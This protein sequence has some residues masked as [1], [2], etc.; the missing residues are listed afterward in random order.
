MA[1]AT[2]GGKTVAPSLS[3][4]PRSYVFS[5]DAANDLLAAFDVAD[6]PESRAFLADLLASGTVPPEEVEL[7]AQGSS[8]AARRTARRQQRARPT[9]RQ[10]APSVSPS[11]SPSPRKR[12]KRA[13]EAR[14]RDSCKREKQKNEKTRRRSRFQTSP[15]ANV[16]SPFFADDADNASLATCDNEEEEESAASI[17]THADVLQASTQ[18]PATSWTRT[19]VVYTRTTVLGGDGATTAKQR[20]TPPIAEPPAQPAA[21]PP[22]SAQGRAGASP[23]KLKLEPRS[24]SPACFSPAPSPSKSTPR[25]KRETTS[26]FFTPPPSRSERQNDESSASEISEIS[27]TGSA[28]EASSNEDDTTHAPS[29]PTAAAVESA[30]PKEE[31]PQKATRPRRG[32]VSGLPFPRLDAP[33]FGLVQERLA[34]E[35]FWLLVALVFLT[36]VAGR[37]SLPVFWD[38]KAR[39]PTP[40]ALVDASSAELVDTMRHLGMASVR[41]A[42]IQRYARGWIARPPSPGVCT[43]V[44]NYPLP[45]EGSLEGSSSSGLP[46]HSQWEIGHLTQG[47]YAVDSWRIFC[48]DALLGRSKH[49]TGDEGGY[50]AARKHSGSKMVDTS[51]SDSSSSGPDD[52]GDPNNSESSENSEYESLVDQDMDRA[53]QPEWMRVLPRDKELRACLR[54]MWMREGW[55]WDPLTGERAVLGEDL[56]CA[57]DEGRV[58]YDV[59]GQLQIVDGE[60]RPEEKKK[61]VVEL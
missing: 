56:R 35:P 58:A 5:L 54:W 1:E 12:P 25:R 41:C 11:P 36:R 31:A 30:T 24:P 42:A 7:L 34:D 10:D 28:S 50:M 29:A 38:I 40:Q 9:S 17:D 39:Y 21:R 44:K 61:L 3:A 37:V 57:V 27:E 13:S 48:R 49:W 20:S 26:Y 2:P 55:N 45:P 19:V 4:S 53:S 33:C 14:S 18:A 23:K 8:S 46:V 16:L 15:K 43:T 51:S 52:S 22:L 6:D 47:A 60:S 59:H 32:T